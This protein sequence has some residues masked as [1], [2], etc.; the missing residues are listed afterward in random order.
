MQFFG[1]LKPSK[2]LI[3]SKLPILKSIDYLILNTYPYKIENQPGCAIQVGSVAGII[4]CKYNVYFCNCNNCNEI[5][6]GY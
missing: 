2:K 1:S 4:K 3:I 6:L 5:Y